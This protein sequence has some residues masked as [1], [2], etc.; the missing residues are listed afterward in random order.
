MNKSYNMH[1]YYDL[2]FKDM[3]PQYPHATRQMSRV[4]ISK[5][6]RLPFLVW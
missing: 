1:Y 4:A 5:A 6:L 3:L 2:H